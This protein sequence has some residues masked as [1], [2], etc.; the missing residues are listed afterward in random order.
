MRLLRGVVAA[1]AVGRVVAA[2]FIVNSSSPASYQNSWGRTE[3]GRAVRRA[4]RP[5]PGRRAGGG[6]G[7][8]HAAG[9][10]N[11]GQMQNTRLAEDAYA[12]LAASSWPAIRGTAVPIGSRMTAVAALS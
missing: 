4:R 6:C 8:V 12:R 3:P 9:S 7:D 1:Y 2:L 10:G 11:G 5:R